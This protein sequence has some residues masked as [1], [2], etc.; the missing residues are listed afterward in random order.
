LPISIFFK[1]PASK[2]KD[3]FIAKKGKA[4][5]VEIWDRFIEF[6]KQDKWEEAGKL[7]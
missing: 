3:A 1:G 6:S 7:L 4:K 5:G 2:L